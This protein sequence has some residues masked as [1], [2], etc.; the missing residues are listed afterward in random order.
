MKRYEEVTRKFAKFFEEDFLTR[1]VEE[2]VDKQELK[3]LIA[4]YTTKD[5][6]SVLLNYV[7]KLTHRL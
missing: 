6:Y 7:M 4:N 2:K 5:S 3:T 1:V